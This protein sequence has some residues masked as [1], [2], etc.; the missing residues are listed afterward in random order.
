MSDAT[1]NN[2]K[3]KS[4]TSLVEPVVPKE[5]KMHFIMLVSCF[6]LWGLLNNMTDNLVPA[7]GRIFMMK[8][9]NSSYV[10]IAFYGA[11]AVLAIPAAIII[12]KWNY[13]AGVLIGLGLYIIGALGYIPAAIFQ[14][15]NFFLVSIFT[16]AGGLSIL[17]TT[18]NPFIISLG[19]Q[20]TSVRRLNFAQAFNPLGSLIGIIMAKFLILGNLNPAGYEERIKMSA[21]TLSSIRTKE[22]MWVCVP[23][24]GLVAVALVIW[25]FFFRNKISAKDEDSNI[26]MKVAVGRLFSRP[27]Y[28]FGV[29]TQFF[30]VGMQIAVWTWMNKYVM[31]V[32][33]VPESRAA[34]IYLMAMVLFILCRWVCTA[35]MKNHDPAKMMAFMAIFGI[36]VSFGTVYLKDNLGVFCLIMISGCMSLMFPTIYG[37][38]LKD[39]GEEVKIGAA[40]LIMAILGGAVIA[41][42]MGKFIDNGTFSTLAFSFSGVEAAV[43]TSY[44]TAAICFLVIFIYSIFNMEKKQKIKK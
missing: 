36:I 22:L 39:M 6:V 15:Y 37:I 23:Y 2:T 43:R 8:S 30:Y 5:Y 13:R 27:K 38:A 7:F 3:V 24:V 20:E 19:S 40:G 16:L 9:V 10:K 32:K 11:Y 33:G 17:E 12:K 25:F 29:I 21:S 44:F 42:L 26:S 4:E 18:C 31:T 28:V 14:N 1:A 41:P 35:L 34:E